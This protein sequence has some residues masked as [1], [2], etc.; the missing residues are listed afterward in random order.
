MIDSV[1]I[2]KEPVLAR[3]GHLFCSGCVKK[4][5]KFHAEGAICPKCKVGLEEKGLIKCEVVERIL[6]V[7]LQEETEDREKSEALS[8]PFFKS[9]GLKK[10]SKKIKEDPSEQ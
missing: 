6:E 9:R 1:G 2:V 7:V 8:T 4:Y 10:M 5:I 3:C